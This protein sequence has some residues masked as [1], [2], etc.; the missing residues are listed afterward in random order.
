METNVG[1]SQGATFLMMGPGS[2]KGVLREVQMEVQREVQGSSERL[3][4]VQ[5]EQIEVQGVKREVR[6]DRHVL[7]R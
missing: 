6:E 1:S 7:Q 2:S 4:G 5:E 3:R